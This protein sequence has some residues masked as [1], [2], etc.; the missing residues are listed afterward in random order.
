MTTISMNLESLLD[1]FN[2]VAEI[3]VLPSLWNAAI[4]IMIEQDLQSYDALHVATARS[5][6]IADFATTDRQYA[7]VEGLTVH[8]ARDS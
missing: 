2:D 5:V 3:P 4:P 6:E 7:R 8:L 1:S